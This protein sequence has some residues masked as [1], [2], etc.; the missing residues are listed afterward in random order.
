M[1]RLAVTFAGVPSAAAKLHVAHLSQ[2]QA[3]P[4]AS[5]GQ[6]FTGAPCELKS[7]RPLLTQFVTEDDRAHRAQN[8]CICRAPVCARPW[9]LRSAHKSGLAWLFLLS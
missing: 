1:L 9:P 5:R 3:L 8:R 7:Q 4:F 2:L 6:T